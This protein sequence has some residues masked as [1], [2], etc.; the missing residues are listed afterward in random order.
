MLL[1]GMHASSKAFI[2]LE[3]FTAG[4]DLDVAIG[5]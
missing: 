3:E 4:N 5:S 2:V 1:E